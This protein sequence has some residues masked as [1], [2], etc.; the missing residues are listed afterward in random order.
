MNAATRGEHQ[1]GCVLANTLIMSLHVA[2][3]IIKEENIEDYSTVRLANSRLQHVIDAI[4]NPTVTLTDEDI[5]GM[6]QI[7]DTLM[8]YIEMTGRDLGSAVKLNGK[9]IGSELE[10][11]AASETGKQVTLDV[12]R[13]LIGV[14]SVETVPNFVLFFQLLGD[15][16]RERE[17]NLQVVA[18]AF[19]FDDIERLKR[20]VSFITHSLHTETIMHFLHRTPYAPNCTKIFSQKDPCLRCIQLTVLHREHTR[21]GFISIEKDGSASFK[22]QLGFNYQEEQTVEHRS[23]ATRIM[24]TPSIITPPETLQAKALEVAGSKKE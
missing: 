22:K 17:N 10:I 5:E 21:D 18:R 19:G 8:R 12:L 15:E 23:K 13:R 14:L 7:L 11:S 4:A 1:H 3:E 9:D 2:G 6:R 24:P 16:S 20:A